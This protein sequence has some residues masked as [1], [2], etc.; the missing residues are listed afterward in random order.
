MCRSISTL[1]RD[2]IAGPLGIRDEVHFGVPPAL[3]PRVARQVP[4]A[5]TPPSPPE[6]GSPL[7]RAM[8]RGVLPDADYA[9]RSDLLTSDI[10]S[11]GT[12][13]AGGVAR[14]Y[15]ALLGHIDGV[16]LVSSRRLACMATVAFTGMDQ[17][18]G[19]P[20]SWAFGYSPPGPV[21]LR[22]GPAR[23]SGWSG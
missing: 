8:P 16:A 14:L 20:T 19:F 23:R 2:L 13:T 21:A 1:L 12:M 11:E 3:V 17:V 9:N 18:M 5:G 22:R 15:S 4:A 7:D 6:R 10:P